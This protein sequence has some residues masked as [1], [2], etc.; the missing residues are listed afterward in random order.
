MTIEPEDRMREK[1]TP[2][3]RLEE[4]KW[5][6]LRHDALRVSLAGRGA[7]AL[8]ANALVATG[9]TILAT[10]R[11]L[12][13]SGAVE[14]SI[15]T[16]A[17]LALI[18]VGASVSYA[19]GAVINIRQW[20]KSY[21]KGLPLALVYDASDTAHG[22]TSFGEFSHLLQRMDLVEALNYAEADLWKGLISYKVRYG[23]L[24]IAVRLLFADLWLFF[25]VVAI[26]LIAGR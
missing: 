4:I 12:N 13:S 24:R 6:L 18:L 1:M 5:H 21:G 22:I 26:Q 20:R 25:A 11:N 2:K 15:T 7:L 3:A 9:V 14:V 10:H 17:I 16:G 23:R 19:T 8:S